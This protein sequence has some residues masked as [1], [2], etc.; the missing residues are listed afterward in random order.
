[1]N[2]SARVCWIIFSI[3]GL[4]C[5]K[6]QKYKLPMKGLKIKKNIEECWI[7]PHH[8]APVGL[9]LSLIRSSKVLIT[10]QSYLYQ[11]ILAT[12]IVANHYYRKEIWCFL[13]QWKELPTRFSVLQTNIPQREFNKWIQ[14]SY[15]FR[16]TPVSLNLMTL[17]C[18]QAP[19]F[20]IYVD[21]HC[22]VNM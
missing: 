3:P 9:Y 22:C 4:N 17:K 2:I 6:P 20:E 18:M 21:S 10:H 13:A 19:Y 1:M 8:Y 12:N 16:K 15:R 11:C 7:Q 14:L 5:E